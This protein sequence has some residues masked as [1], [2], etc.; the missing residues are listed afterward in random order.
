M[1]DVIF[2]VMSDSCPMS[3]LKSTLISKFMFLLDCV[4]LVLVYFGCDMFLVTNYGSMI[5]MT[6]II[7]CSHILHSFWHISSHCIRVSALIC[8]LNILDIIEL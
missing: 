4:G 6:A 1:P 2:D 8:I 7:G 3:Y 5:D